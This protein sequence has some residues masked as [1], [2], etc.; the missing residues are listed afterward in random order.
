MTDCCSEDARAVDICAATASDMV[1]MKR[2]AVTPG[3]VNKMCFFQSLQGAT[4]TNCCPDHP[5][6]MASH[7]IVCR[8]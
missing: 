2:F 1:A 4:V 7:D 6:K 3:D 5:L 8:K